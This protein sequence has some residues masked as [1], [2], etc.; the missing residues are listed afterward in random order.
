MGFGS[1]VAS[2]GYRRDVPMDRGSHGRHVYSQI[3]SQAPEYT[4]TVRRRTPPA[5][6]RLV[7]VEDG[8]D[9][10][11]FLHKLEVTLGNQVRRTMRVLL[12]RYCSEGVSCEVSG[13][14]LA[15]TSNAHSRAALSYI[16]PLA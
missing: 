7:P 8:D 14:P 5:V 11:R 10:A 4:F 13:G 15:H 2:A 9:D 3:V 16:D 12:A 1:L 6:S